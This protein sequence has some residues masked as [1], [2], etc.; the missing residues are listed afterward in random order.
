M[1]LK[2][3]TGYYSFIAFRYRECRNIALQLTHFCVCWHDSVVAHDLKLNSDA[4]INRSEFTVVHTKWVFYTVDSIVSQGTT[5][6]SFLHTLQY[7]CDLGEK[8]SPERST[9]ESREV[10]HKVS[11]L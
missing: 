4:Y 7:H 10:C 11:E 2:N 8:D 6:N 5:Y 1:T 3:S 9:A